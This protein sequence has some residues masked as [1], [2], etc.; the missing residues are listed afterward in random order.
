MG[1]SLDAAFKHFDTDGSGRISADELLGVLKHLG[2][3]HDITPQDA[4]RFI[5][6][7]SDDHSASATASVSTS[8]K[9]GAGMSKEAFFEFVRYCTL[10]LSL[11]LFLCV[12]TVQSCNRVLHM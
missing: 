12:R 7:F 11:S 1:T 10:I 3:F 6:G 5:A 4:Q 9:S 2:Q 8:S